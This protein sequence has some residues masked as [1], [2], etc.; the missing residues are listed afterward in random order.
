MTL[1]VILVVLVERRA[2]VG[3]DLGEGFS[4]SFILF[5]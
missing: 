5:L 2:G 3:L 1:Q 4:Q